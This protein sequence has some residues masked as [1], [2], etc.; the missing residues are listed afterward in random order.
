MRV[1]WEIGNYH[2]NPCDNQTSGKYEHEI[3]ELPDMEQYVNVMD[4]LDEDDYNY[5]NETAD[6]WSGEDAMVEGK[7][8]R[9]DDK[10]FYYEVWLSCEDH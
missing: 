9:K 7:T 4:F 1:K 10:G 3:D 2:V 6:C 5:I 8:L